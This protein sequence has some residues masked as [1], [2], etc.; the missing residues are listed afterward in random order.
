MIF[1]D[2]PLE[3]PDEFEICCPLCGDESVENVDCDNWEC[4]VCDLTFRDS[5][6]E[7]DENV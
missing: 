4:L 1:T 7:E 3:P 6:Y 5:Y 2:G